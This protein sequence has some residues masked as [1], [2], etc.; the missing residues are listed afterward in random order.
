MATAFLEHAATW[1]KVIT[2]A[3]LDGGE[4][5]RK[6]IILLNIFMLD[7]ESRYQQFKSGYLEPD[8]WEGAQENTP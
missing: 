1:E 3:P 2:G 6:A 7:I 8:S 5:T 4:E